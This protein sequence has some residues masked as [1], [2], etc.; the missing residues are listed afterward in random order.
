MSALGAQA[1][2]DTVH[3]QRDLVRLILP[4]CPTALRPRLLSL[5]SNY[6]LQAGWLLYDLNDFDSASYY[7]EHAR[8]TAHEAETPNSARSCSAP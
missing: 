5:Y 8:A 3:S 4:E 6:S 7:Y 2:L 1:T